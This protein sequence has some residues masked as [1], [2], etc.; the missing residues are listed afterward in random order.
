MQKMDPQD[1]QL[2]TEILDKY[3]LKKK[4][5]YENDDGHSERT[6]YFSPKCK[7]PVP[8]IYFMH[9]LSSKTHKFNCVRFHYSDYEITIDVG[10]RSLRISV[11]N[12]PHELACR[13]IK[14][15]PGIATHF[16]CK[17][18]D[19]RNIETIS[20]TFDDMR[21]AFRELPRSGV[22]DQI[23]EKHIQKL[24]EIESN[25]SK[26]ISE[27]FDEKIA[28]S[29]NLE[30][31]V[32]TRNH[33]TFYEGIEIHKHDISHEQQVDIFQNKIINDRIIK[34]IINKY[35]KFHT[36]SAIVKNYTSIYNFV[37]TKMSIKI[38]FVFEL[39][40]N[41]I[42]Y[43]TYGYYETA[44]NNGVNIGQQLGVDINT[45]DELLDYIFSLNIDQF[46]Q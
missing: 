29:F 32:Y 46:P 7:I 21:R 12:I 33:H 26:E 27:I 3:I 19:P 9:W 20:I 23:C 10:E 15:R 5:I 41:E 8:Q 28:I 43:T 11:Y 34:R 45:S 24:K 13:N 35:A 17:S 16:L 37:E 1:I 2:A 14:Y 30:N 18:D 25:V 38:N 42:F 22:K 6:L 39:F 36:Y 31:K 4:L 40:P 44:V